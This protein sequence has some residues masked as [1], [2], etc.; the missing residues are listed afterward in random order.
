ME[1]PKTNPGIVKVSKTHFMAKISSH[2]WLGNA[3]VPS[4]QAQLHIAS[5]AVLYGLS[6]YTVFPITQTPH[7]FYV[8]QLDEH[9][10]R[11]QN[12]AKLIGIECPQ[13]CQDR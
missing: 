3:I 5:S 13:I 8:F 9:L 2:I 12:S 11:L 7:G 6:V 10:R 1:S 4:D